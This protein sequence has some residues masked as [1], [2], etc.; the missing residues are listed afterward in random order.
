[1]AASVS[2]TDVEAAMDNPAAPVAPATQLAPDEDIV[3]VT[4]NDEAGS[5]QEHLSSG[6]FESSNT[7]PLPTTTPAAAAPPA[8]E[9][10]RV[11]APPPADPAVGP[12]DEDSGG[13]SEDGSAAE[14]P[15]AAAPAA[16]PRAAGPAPRAGR[17]RHAYLPTSMKRA[18]SMLP[19]ELRETSIKLVRLLMG[20]P[21]SKHISL[22][23]L[24]SLY[25][26][27]YNESLPLEALGFDSLAP[28]LLA[29]ERVL[30]LSHDGLEAVVEPASPPLADPSSY[31]HLLD[32]AGS[33]VVA[34]LRNFPR[35]V[36]LS[37]LRD[38]YFAFYHNVLPHQLL[39]FQVGGFLLA[40]VK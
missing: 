32:V 22:R 8:V 29:M 31:A 13:V 23:L 40:P 18:I 6:D 21:A 1:M 34:L 27:H 30:H 2:S 14:A 35:G 17:A 10:P 9:A 28:M 16:A 3:T 24:P 39:C 38:E 25:F 37:R 19:V 26:A 12:S 4:E 11:T 36:P 33:H 7:L 5:E 15:R 20:R